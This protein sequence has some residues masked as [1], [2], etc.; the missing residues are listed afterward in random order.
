MASARRNPK[1]GAWEVRAYAGKDPVT[2]KVRNLSDTLPPDAPPEDVEAA[3]ARLDGAAA[4][5][6][7]SRVPWTVPGLLAYDLTRLPALGFSPTTVDSYRSN[8]RRY[9]DPYMGGVGASEALPW[10]FSSLFSRLLREGAKDGGPLSRNTVRKLRSQL[11]AAFDRLVEDRVVPANPVDGARGPR[12]ERAESDALC[13][14]D[15]AALAARLDAS[16]GAMEAAFR[17][18]LDTGVRRGEL[19]GL[20]VKDYSRRKGGVRV[21]RS[22]VQSKSAGAPLT[23]K[24]PK[25]RSSMRFVEMSEGSMDRLDAHLARQEAR[26]AARGLR[27]GGDTPLFARDDGSPIRPSALTAGFRSLADDLGLPKSA[28]L[29]TLRH[30]HASVLLDAGVGVKAVQERLGHCSPSVTLNVYGHAMDGSASS[31]AEAWE[32]AAGDMERR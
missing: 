16:D 22:L 13:G 31:A 5:C 1:T 28:H 24:E 3:K 8:L 20:E 4:F 15:V 26:L 30:T 25:S 18:D 29:H 10:M 6:K 14:R 27:M 9:V 19:A 32:R 12:Q 21:A 23:Y 2:G 17:F 7:S 11:H